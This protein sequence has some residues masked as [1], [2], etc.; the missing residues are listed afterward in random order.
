MVRRQEERYNDKFG[1]FIVDALIE[2]LIQQIPSRKQIIC[3][4][5]SPNNYHYASSTPYFILITTDSTEGLCTT[6]ND[7]GHGLPLQQSDCMSLYFFF[8]FSQKILMK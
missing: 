6:K 4:A 7:G 8:F 1:D 2:P 5:K 3:I